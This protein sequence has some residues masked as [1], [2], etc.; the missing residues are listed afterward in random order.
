MFGLVALSAGGRGRSRLGAGAASSSGSAA[1]VGAGV[2]VFAIA[3]APPALDRTAPIGHAPTRSRRDSSSLS[4]ALIPDIGIKSG[5]PWRSVPRGGILRARGD[6]DRR[7][8]AVGRRAAPGGSATP[9]SHSRSCRR[10]SFGPRLAYRHGLILASC[11]SR[12]W[13]AERITGWDGPIAPGI[14]ALVATGAMIAAPASIETRHVSITNRCGHLSPGSIDV[15]DWTQRY[16]PL[17]WPRTGRRSSTS[18]RS[19]RL[20][21]DREPGPLRGF[22]WETGSRPSRT[23]RGRRPSA[24]NRWTPDEP[25]D[26]P[27]DRSQEDRRW[28]PC[29]GLLSQVAEPGAPSGHGWRPR[30][31]RATA[32]NMGGPTHRDR[33]SLTSRPAADS[34]RVTGLLDEPTSIRSGY[35]TPDQPILFPPFGTHAAT[36]GDDHGSD[37]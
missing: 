28:V 11:S 35:G 29:R 30:C 27:R 34:Y 36:G 32:T 14:A 22:G 2:V 24:L 25:G 21:E 10:Y 9:L 7:S 15:F 4:R 26:A 3:G 12:S 20:L 37:G 13:G 19:T 23:R 31:S 6:P 8:P 16:G 1:L 18:R 33:V 17:D 5:C